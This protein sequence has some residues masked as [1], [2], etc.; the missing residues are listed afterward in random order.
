[1]KSDQCDFSWQHFIN[2]C[3]EKFQD[4]EIFK[5]AECLEECTQNISSMACPDFDM[6]YNFP[7]SA[8]CKC[9]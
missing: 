1:M 3:V 9:A 8:L 7:V 5:V 4:E 2:K 6:T